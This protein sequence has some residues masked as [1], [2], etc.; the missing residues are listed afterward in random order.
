MLGNEPGLGGSD[1]IL[2]SILLC[3]PGHVTLDCPLPFVCLGSGGSFRET[4]PLQHKVLWAGP[5]FL[6]SGELSWDVAR[7][8]KG[9]PRVS[10]VMLLLP[11]PVGGSAPAE[12]SSTTRKL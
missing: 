9:V 10:P 8:V 7:A 1:Q 5:S 2:D 12:G 11:A 6:H 3:P 4:P